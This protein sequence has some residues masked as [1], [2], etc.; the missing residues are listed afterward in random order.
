MLAA[1]GAEVE[2]ARP[3]P[4]LEAA[5]NQAMGLARSGQ[6]DQAEA[7]LDRILTAAPRQPDALQLKGMVARQRGDQQAAAD[8]FRRSLA[9]QPNQPHVL[10]NLGNS[11]TALGE[12]PEAVR[13]YQQAISLKPDYAD[14]R[15]N[16]ALAQIASDNPR[17]AVTTL[18]PLVRALPVNARAW[19]VLGQA[20]SALD[21]YTHAIKAYR[22][23]LQQH[24]DHAP[25]LHNLAVA[26]R[27][28]GRAQEALPL[29]QTCADRSPGEARIHYNLGHCL[30]DLGRADEA[31]GAYRRALALTPTDAAV[32]DSLSRLLW[33]QGDT[34]G[35]L[36]SYREAL[37]A[38]P[39][40]PALLAG[41]A[42]RLTLSGRHDEAAALLAGPAA[43]GIGGADLH[44]RHGQACWSA[45]NADQAFA[46]F[47][48]AL[49]I[50]PGHAPSLRESARCL[51]IA[52]RLAPAADRLARR[53]DDDPFD[54]QALALQ[55]LSWRLTGDPR[56]A[57]LIDPA[58]IGAIRLIPPS[59]DGAAFNRDLD[60][61]LDALHTSRQHPLEQT[62]RGGTQTTDDLFSRDLPELLA[63]RAMIEAAIARH[64]AALP[65]DPS[66]PFLARKSEAFRFSG[67]W[68]V[69]LASGGHHTNHIHPEGWISAV[70]YVAVPDAVGDGQSGWL[71]F[72]ET[73]LQLGAREQMLHSIRP[74]PGLLVLFPSYLYHGTI[75]FADAAHRTT[76][77]FDVVPVR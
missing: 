42:N 57:W 71:K 27:L 39:D 51:I 66:H 45:G 23:A 74:E 38:A 8:C 19:A 16:L 54:Q 58:L 5:L 18:E 44:Y 52:D 28:A 36:S 4:S 1:A 56:A 49:A 43:R 20:Y 77:A 3:Q 6:L 7:V 72:G 75:P 22:A 63:V 73:G 12:H 21:D 35:H 10:N 46:A 26:L 33:Q 9:V 68:S 29:L 53:L 14:A 32:H 60:R 61:A 69:R 17:Q 37:A 11:L 50:D 30:Q 2:L 70:Y 40:D 62:L 76:I 55:G 24:P 65:D 25:W 47:D 15:I 48:A 67:S 41:L 64:V 31:A 34:L 13:A 59:G